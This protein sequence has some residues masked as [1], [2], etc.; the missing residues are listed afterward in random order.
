MRQIMGLLGLGKSSR[1][2]RTAHG[3]IGTAS[4]RTG[5]ARCKNCRATVRLGT[6]RCAQCGTRVIQSPSKGTPIADLGLTDL[7]TRLLV[8]AAH[9]KSRT[10][11]VLPARGSAEGEVKAGALRIS[12]DE[13]LRA[14]E[15]LSQAG[16]VEPTDDTSF[17]V[18][19]KGRK[20]VAKLDEPI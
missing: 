15:Q 17:M 6:L 18:T 13:G 7:Q 1:P 19:G 5:F 10:I 2:R 9:S 8:A 14:V 16:L 3:R 4:K 12:G 11:H 20:T